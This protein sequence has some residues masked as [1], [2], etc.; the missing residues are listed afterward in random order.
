MF[1]NNYAEPLGNLK[2]KITELHFTVKEIDSSR[3]LTCLQVSLDNGGGQIENCIL[4][5]WNRFQ[6]FL[7][8]LSIEIHVCVTVEIYLHTIFDF[9]KPSQRMGQFVTHYV[10]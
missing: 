1:H 3:L 4:L 5:K 10:H 9:Y 2:I 8:K 6:K 7:N